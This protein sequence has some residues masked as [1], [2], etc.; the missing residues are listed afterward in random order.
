MNDEQEPACDS[1]VT[2]GDVAVQVKVVGLLPGGMARADTGTGTE[3][4]SVALVEAQV[5]DTVLVHAKEAI[6]VVER[7]ES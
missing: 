6:V 3:E 2:C 4:I 7:A 1:C 5:G